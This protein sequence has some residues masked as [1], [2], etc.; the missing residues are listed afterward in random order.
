MLRNLRHRLGLD[1]APDK[2]R[3]LAASAS[4]EAGRDNDFLE[5]FF[6]LPNGRHRVIPGALELPP[7]GPVDLSPHAGEL[8]EAAER[9]LD[10]DEAVALLS[11]S[12]A[13]DALARVLAPEGKPR[14]VPMPA[15]AA[16]LFPE[17][18]SADTQSTALHG[19][20][21]ALS[22]ADSSAFPKLRAHMSFRNIDVW[23]SSHCSAP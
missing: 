13:G 19:L 23:L 15:I 18:K 8:A 7:V 22:R 17:L 14:A 6:A 12:A 16:E 11:R 20:L 21:R 10:R 2:F 4:L 9:D 5:S 3:V 1:E